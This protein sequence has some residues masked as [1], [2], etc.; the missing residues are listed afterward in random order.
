VSG[1]TTNYRKKGSMPV[2]TVNVTRCVQDSQ[3]YGST[4]E[5]MVS[6]VFYSIDVD[7]VSKG[8]DYSDLKQVV[9]SAYSSDNI[10]VS[11]PK[12]Y[13][14]P[15]DHKSFSNEMAGYFCKCVNSS[16]AVLS[17]GS[18]AQFR[19]KNNTFAIPYRFQFEAEEQ[20][21]SW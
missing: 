20:A 4:D 3:E 10:E 12:G 13:R 17:L 7:G 21:A 11:P 8:N 9:G 1:F 19:M 14:G 15:Y 2:V 18:A 5:Y 16:G 6:R